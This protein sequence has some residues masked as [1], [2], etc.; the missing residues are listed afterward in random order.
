MLKKVILAKHLNIILSEMC[1]RVGTD[2]T[3]VNILQDEWQELHQWSIEEEQAFQDW[4]YKYLVANTDALFE[5]ST[6]KPQELFTATELMNLV[7]EFT[8]FYGWA[9]TEEA[10]LE[11]IKEHKPN[12]N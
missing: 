3:R 9:L 1:S 2:L 11:N 8:L 6:L 5:I 4:M 10:D 12:K 7:K